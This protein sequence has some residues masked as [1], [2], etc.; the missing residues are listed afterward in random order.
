M[1]MK[2]QHLCPMLTVFDMK[3]SL[4]FYV[5]VLGF[6]IH[7]SAGEEHD[8]GWEWLTR[9]DL[10]LM[11]NTQYEIRDRP[12]HPDNSRKSVHNDTIL[13][14]GCPDVDGA[15]QELLKKG[16][17]IGPPEVASYGMKQLYFH[18]PDGY[19]ICL[20]FKTS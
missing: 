5:D 7:E 10:N 20:Q 12:V 18:D 4:K 2:I 13:Y 9:N 14:L 19:K 6:K 1:P 3:E 8:I 16:L 11:L 17:K 15:F